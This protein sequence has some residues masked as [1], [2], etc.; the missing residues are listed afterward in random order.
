VASCGVFATMRAASSTVSAGNWL[1]I[2]FAS[3]VRPAS[4]A[5]SG[6]CVVLGSA[7]LAR[8]AGAFA[9]ADAALRGLAFGV[10]FFVAMGL[11][12]T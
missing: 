10:G 11:H 6:S 2:G 1:S 4:A 8:A 9:L 7:A 12:S 5:A 3:T